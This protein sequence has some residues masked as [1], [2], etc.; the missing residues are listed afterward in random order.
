MNTAVFRRELL[1]RLR[2]VR[3]VM[4]ILAFAVLACLLVY[5]RW[6][7]DSRLEIVSGDSKPDI[8]N[9][10][11]MPDMLSRGSMLVFAPLAYGLA[12]A[13]MLLVPAFPATALVKERRRGTLT[14]LL[15]SPMSPLEI[16]GGKLAANFLL[17]LILISTCLPALAACYAMGGLT[18]IDHIVPLLIVLAAM[19]LQYSTVGLL[20]SV[21]SSTS[22]SSLRWTYAAVL[23][24]TLLTLA[25]AAIIGNIDS[26]KGTAARWMT[27]LSPAGSLRELTGT[28]AASADLGLVGSWKGYVLS[29]CLSS[30]VFAV[31]TLVYPDPYRADRSKPKGRLTH[32]RGFWRPRLASL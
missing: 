29:A 32:E 10:D 12:A 23:M 15:N 16:Y 28:V 19:S 31:I 13:V 20:I 2:A 7:S 25:P 26:W 8:V 22:D 14:L 17:A 21:R 6:P 1:D 24:L 30:L 5:M 3:T 18:I 11:S 4:S 27:T 9:R